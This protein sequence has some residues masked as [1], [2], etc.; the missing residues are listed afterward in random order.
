MRYLL[1]L[2]L[3]PSL[4]LA[5]PKYTP[6]VIPKCEVKEL[7][8]KTKG[9][10]Y[11]LEQLKELFKCDSDLVKL[12]KTNPLQKQKIKLQ[13][14]IILSQ[15][16]QMELMLK[17]NKLFHNR[18]NSLTKLYIDT[19]KKLQYELVKPK[20]GSYISWGVA[21]ALA[22]SFTGYVVADQVAK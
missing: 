14:D 21:V 5:E 20:W 19:D 1:T 2:L 6:Q 9:C 15:K 12:R 17:N 3:L 10:V 8:D 22:A 7:N 11:T 4:A 16:L 18:M 13:Q